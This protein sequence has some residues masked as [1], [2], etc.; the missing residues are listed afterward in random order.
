M[1][2]E[3]EWA[4]TLSRVIPI[5]FFKNREKDFEAK[6]PWTWIVFSLYAVLA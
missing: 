4:I 2:R 6:T 3:A 5:F 1:R